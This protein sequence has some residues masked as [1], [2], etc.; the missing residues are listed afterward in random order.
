MLLADK[1]HGQDIGSLVFS[2]D[3]YKVN[4]LALGLLP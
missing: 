1:S 4:L 3:I 2:R